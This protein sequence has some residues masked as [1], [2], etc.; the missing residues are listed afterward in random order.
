MG[1]H[2]VGHDGSN[3]AAAAATHKNQRFS[4][5]SSSK[6]VMTR[7]KGFFGDTKLGER[8]QCHS[9]LELWSH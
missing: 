8:A 7:G 5:G 1:S 6:D 4:H 3:L 2:R 9:L